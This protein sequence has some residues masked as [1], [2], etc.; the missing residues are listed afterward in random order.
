[1][2]LLA[3]DR[4][5]GAELSR[6]HFVGEVVL[7]CHFAEAGVDGLDEAPGRGR[8]RVHGQSVDAGLCRV[9]PT[10]AA[11]PTVTWIPGGRNHR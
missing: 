8:H 7:K 10:L 1:M 2:V 4:V 9:L 5:G 11:T 6:N 3:G